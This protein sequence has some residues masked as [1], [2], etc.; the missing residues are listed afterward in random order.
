M[1]TC[2]IEVRDILMGIVLLLFS[3]GLCICELINFTFG[4]V[5]KPFRQDLLETLNI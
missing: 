4:K 5:L 3:L 2:I 1:V